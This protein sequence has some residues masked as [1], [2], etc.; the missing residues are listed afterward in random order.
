MSDSPAK[1][2]NFDVADKENTPV[3]TTIVE[4]E[5]PA[6]KPEAE[7][8]KVPATAKDFEADEPLLQDNPNRFVLFPIKY[9]EVRVPKPS[10][11]DA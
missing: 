1:K 6:S 3:T 2:L 11:R 9:H 10:T 5:K 4:S 8:V 7:Q